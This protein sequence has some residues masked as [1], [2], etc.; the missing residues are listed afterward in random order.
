MDLN[1]LQAYAEAQK[2]KREELDS[3]MWTM[4]MYVREA[5]LSSVCNGFFWK[6][7]NDKPD[8]YPDKPYL[9]TMK[10]TTIE[11]EVD[12]FF[13]QEEARRLNWKRTHPKK[14]DAK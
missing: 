11:K 1:T 3:Q 13:A 5:L 6:N 9:Q 8:S 2:L 12:K 10:Q 14:V 7:K 4:G